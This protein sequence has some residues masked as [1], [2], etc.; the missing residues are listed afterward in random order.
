MQPTFKK[1]MEP[2]MRQ[3]P[4]HSRACAA[5]PHPGRRE[6]PFPSSAPIPLLGDPADGIGYYY[7]IPVLT[8]NPDPTIFSRLST[9]VVVLFALFLCFLDDA[10]L[11]FHF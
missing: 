10:R 2:C 7:A 3:R 1:G 9:F 5:M 4:N 8:R 6:E 11:S